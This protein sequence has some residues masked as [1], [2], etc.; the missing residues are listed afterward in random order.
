MRTILIADENADVRKSISLMF[1]ECVDYRIAT[2]SSG[3]D[4]IFKA[5]KIKPDIVLADTSLSD[6]N[7][8]EVSREI[9]NNPL[10]NNTSV[11]LLIPSFEVFDEGMAADVLADD[12]MIKPINAEETTKKVE[13][14]IKQHEKKEDEETM[15]KRKPEPFGTIRFSIENRENSYE[16]TEESAQELKMAIRMAARK[17]KGRK[18]IP[19]QIPTEAGY[20]KVPLYRRRYSIA[21]LGLSIILFVI[22]LFTFTNEK[23]EESWFS[24]TSTSID[25][26]T[27][28]RLNLGSGTPPPDG[29]SLKE[30]SKGIIPVIPVKENIGNEGIKGKTSSLK[31]RTRKIYNRKTRRL[32]SRTQPVLAFNR[33]EKELLEQQLK[34]AFLLY[35]P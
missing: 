22:V 21:L 3:A 33:S 11:I 24:N 27:Q 23:E 14:L 1:S 28:P 12:F 8:Y 17:L 5:K 26:S 4:A 32:R 15:E 20:L 2:T 10:L 25:S 35:K 6:K 18:N 9:K 30:A 19:H 7:G 29:K 13:S 16:L 31:G 34:M